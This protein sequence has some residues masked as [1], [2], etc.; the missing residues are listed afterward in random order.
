[1][2]KEPILSSNDI[3]KEK[4][5]E[6]GANVHIHIDLIRHPEKDPDTGKLTEKGKEAFFNNLLKNFQEGEEYDTTKFYVSPLSRGQESKEPIAAFLEASNIPTTI[7]DK[8]ELVGRA[9]EIGPAFKEEMAKVLEQNEAL[10]QKQIEEAREKDKSIATYEPAS[11]DYET[12]TNEI[13]I[14]D[15]FSQDFP[16]ST[17]T[18]EDMAESIKGL[19]DHFSE[20]ASRLKSNSKVKLVLIGHSGVIEHFTKYV[21]LQNHPEIKPEDVDAETIGGLVEFGEGPEITILTDQEGKPEIKLKFKNLE[22]SY[23]HE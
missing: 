10:T 23:Q 6:R 19:V 15:Y 5:P 18:G 3:E 9:M 12:K 1:M 2:E 17:L 8:K 20:M 11:K 21:Y 16:G 4:N 14:R 13:L 7:R 22:L